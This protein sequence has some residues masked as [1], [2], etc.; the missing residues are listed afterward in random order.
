MNYLSEISK[1]SNQLPHDVLMD[2]DKRCSDWM[3]SGGKESDQYIKQQLRYAKN[4]IAR[5][6]RK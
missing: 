2:I 4:V 6:E 3:A 1:I 5:K